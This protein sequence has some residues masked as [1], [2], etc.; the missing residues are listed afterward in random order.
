[1]GN[2]L[3]WVDKATSR[4]GFLAGTGKRLS[5]IGLAVT[6]A[7]VTANEA[8]AFHRACCGPSEAC[9]TW[10]YGCPTTVGVCSSSCTNANYTW[11]CCYGGRITYCWDCYCG[12]NRCNCY[13]ITGAI[14]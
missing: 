9:G 14:C 13:Q 3:S 10:G 4:R 11:A 7:G 2:V 1:M 5:A 8:L 12:G 6:A